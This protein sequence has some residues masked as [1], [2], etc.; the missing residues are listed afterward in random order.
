MPEFK[1]RRP[2]S[3]TDS[4][5]TLLTSSSGL[6]AADHAAVESH[7]AQVGQRLALADKAR[8]EVAALHAER[9]FREDPEN[10][11]TYAAMNS[12]L[13]LPIARQ[14]RD[15]MLGVDGVERPELTPDQDRLLRVALGAV[16]GNRLATGKTNAQQMAGAGSQ[17]LD[18]MLV[19]R[20]AD[21]TKASDQAPVLAAAGRKVREPFSSPNAQGLAINQESGEGAIINEALY[22]AALDAVKAEGFQ[23]RS[24]GNASNASAG[25][26]DARRRLTNREI[27]V[28]LPGARAEA[29]RASTRQREVNADAKEAEANEDRAVRQQ[30][31]ARDRFRKDPQMKGN[32]VGVW[33]PGKGF[34]V[35][36]KDGK[37][38]GYYD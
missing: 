28:D 17:N 35:R 16:H 6:T 33:V 19:S 31:E 30:T 11:L 15:Y 4:L 29:A 12:G 8:E 32:R 9:A 13:T 2:A 37:L 23:R 36:S 20:A 21:L 3:I 38:I 7:S 10:A 27:D 25:E 22:R 1:I 5:R 26:R 34:E 24:A 14:A 18:T